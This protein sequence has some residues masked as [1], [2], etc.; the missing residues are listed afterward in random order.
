MKY[1]SISLDQLDIMHLIQVNIDISQRQIAQ[2]SGFSIGKV[3]YCLKELIDIGFI[4]VE[5]FKKST[6]KINYV[7]ILTPKGIHEKALITKKFIIKNKQEYYK[8]K[9]YID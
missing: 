3:N 7:Y 4:K 2:K 5:N 8:L 9:S 6:Q 1:K